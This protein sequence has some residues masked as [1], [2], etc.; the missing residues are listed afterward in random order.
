VVVVGAFLVA[1]GFCGLVAAINSGTS[2][3]LFLIGI[4]IFVY[5]L[6]FFDS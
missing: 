3:I 4:A 5:G 2:L 1:V 6:G